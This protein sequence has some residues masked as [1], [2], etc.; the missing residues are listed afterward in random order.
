MSKCFSEIRCCPSSPHRRNVREWNSSATYNMYSLLKDFLAEKAV[1]PW[2]KQQLVSCHGVNWSSPLPL[3]LLAITTATTK[4]EDE[5]TPLPGSVC[6][7]WAGPQFCTERSQAAATSLSSEEEN[8]GVGSMM[9]STDP[10]F[11]CTS[12]CVWSL[13]SLNA[14]CVLGKA[15]QQ[16]RTKQSLLARRVALQ[17]SRSKKASG[18]APFCADARLSGDKRKDQAETGDAGKAIFISWH[19]EWRER[20]S[21]PNFQCRSLETENS[22]AWCFRLRRAFDT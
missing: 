13:F 4:A 21:Y 16:R 15:L 2:V 10:L 22:Q 18:L 9:L 20:L 1:H 3:S 6:P 11:R 17:K 14:V 12:C 8:S 7:D 5:A 19:R